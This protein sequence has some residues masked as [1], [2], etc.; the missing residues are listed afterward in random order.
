MATFIVVNRENKYHDDQSYQD[1]IRYILQ[2]QK[3]RHNLIGGYA[4][5]P[6]QATLEMEMLTKFW[7]KDHGVHLRHMVLSFTPA[8]IKD[9]FE[10]Y[11]IA[12]NAVAFYGRTYQIIFAVHEDSDHLHIHIVMNMVSYLDG[13]KYAGRTDDYHAF[14]RHLQDILRKYNLR[15]IPISS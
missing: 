6:E 10:A 12:I 14:C 8:E 7:R 1:V 15:L 5:S 4:V 9:P 3:C 13:K 11:D 2:P